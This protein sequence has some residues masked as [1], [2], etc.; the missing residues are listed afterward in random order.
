M[1]F[2]SLAPTAQRVG[3][4][5]TIEFTPDGRRV[6]HNTDL[7]GFG[8]ALHEFLTAADT[9]VP[10]SSIPL[11][12]LILGRGGAARAVETVLKAR[13][14]PYWYVSRNP[15]AAGLAYE[16]L[17]SAILHQHRLIINTTPL[18]TWP[19]VDACP[20]LPYTALTPAQIGRAH[21]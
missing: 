12:A 9:A 5:N 18:G 19:D 16:E 6:G 11:R 17:T 13:G 20:A 4:V 2:R 8:T 3:A 21:V 15:L 7:E 14:I 10:F 1:L